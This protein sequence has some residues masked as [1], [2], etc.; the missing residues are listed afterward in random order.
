MPSLKTLELPS[1]CGLE[2]AS[3]KQGVLGGKRGTTRISTE[4]KKGGVWVGRVANAACR[5]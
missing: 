1:T 2:A 5:N 3:E 4:K